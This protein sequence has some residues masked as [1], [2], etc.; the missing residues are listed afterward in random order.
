MISL[1]KELKGKWQERHAN[2]N[3][4]KHVL[5]NKTLT[6]ALS[7]LAVPLLKTQPAE[8]KTET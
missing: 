6:E 5:E 8:M 7:K 4:Y 1:R 2:N 3:A